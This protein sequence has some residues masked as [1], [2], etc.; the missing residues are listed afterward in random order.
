MRWGRKGI[1]FA[2]L[3]RTAAHLFSIDPA[4]RLITRVS[5]PEDHAFTSFTFTRDFKH[6][7]MLEAGSNSSSEVAVSALDLFE[8]TRLTRL[9][10]QFSRFQT[11]TRELVHWKSVDGT[12]IEGVLIKP[13]GFDPSK[14]YPVLA[15]D[16]YYPVEEFVAKGALV[17]RPNYRG[18]AGYGEKFRALNVRN[19]GIG[20]SWDVLS[21][22]D[23]LVAK[24]WA[25]P[26]R[27]GVM[28]WSQ[29]GYISAFL[30]T[31]SD[32]F[33]AVSVGAGISDWTAYYVSTDIHP[34]TRQYLKATPWDDPDIYRKT[35]PISNVNHART[36]TLIQHGELDKRVP[37][38]NAYELE[39]AL[40]DRDVPVRMVVYKGFG[41]S[42]DK[43]KQQRAVMQE[44]LDWF[45]RWL[46]EEKPALVSGQ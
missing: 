45:N 5:A 11:G 39:Q 8:Q 28:G 40:R 43:P 27:V 44:N 1:Y 4:T 10:E 22:V 13:A 29:G 36:P 37:I 17:L 12:L 23:Y 15:A 33:R 31:S 35:S 42:I 21:G 2:A 24:G 38:A 20:D 16:R 9:G 46:W 3:Q 6:V 30:A 25:D 18:S 14:K 41:H 32:R 26:D 34:F 7:A 19:L